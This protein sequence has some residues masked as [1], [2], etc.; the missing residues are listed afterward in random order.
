MRIRLIQPAQL[1]ANGNPKRFERLFFP[2]LTLPTI[3]GITPS[4]VDIGITIEYVDDIDF[5]EKT[6]LVGITA[7]TCQAPRAYQIADEFRKRGTK[8]IIGGIHA[9]ICPDEALQHFDSVL[10]GEAENLWDR[11]LEDVRAGG[12]RCKYEASEKPDLTRLVVPRYDL[13]DY[14]RYV[15]PPFARTPLIPI[16][17]TRGCPH[18]CDFCSVSRFWGH[19]HRKKPVDHVIREI[20]AIAPSRIFFSDDNIGADA[21][22]AKELFRALKPLKTRWAC[23]MSTR[24]MEDPELI[25]LAGEAGCHETLLGI[26]SLN[27]ASLSSIHKSF[28]KVEHYESLLKRLRE[29]GILAQVS[30]IFGLDEDNTDNLRRTIDT[31][32]RWDANYVYI[33]ILTPFPGTR[34]YQRFKDQGRLLDTN[35][36]RYDVTDVVYMP[37]NMTTE[38]LKDITWEMYEKCYSAGNILQRAWRFKKQYVFFF[39]RDNMIEEVFFQFHMRNSIKKRC[40]PFSVGM[41]RAS[42]AGR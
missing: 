33:A 3:A 36:S 19:R 1:D 6:D 7:Q 12:L 18:D 10:I 8:T 42:Y 5:D 30:V 9:S 25:E 26:E 17:A 4:G 27:E 23:Q 2:D 28:N 14:G 41:E 16:Q 40:H 24:I 15:V 37:R 13:L 31:L 29:A 22:Y 34:L 35:W 32:L 20:E 39:P 21:Q 11:V 38:D